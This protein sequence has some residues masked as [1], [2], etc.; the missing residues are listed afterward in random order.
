MSTCPHDEGRGDVFFLDSEGL[1][2]PADGD[3]AELLDQ[4]EI[5]N[6]G[7]LMDDFTNAAIVTGVESTLAIGIV[8]EEEN[9]VRTNDGGNGGSGRKRVLEVAEIANK[10]AIGQAGG[11]IDD[12]D[13]SRASD[14]E[15]DTSSGGSNP[16][17]GCTN[18]F[19]TARDH[20]DNSIDT[21]AGRFAGVGEWK[22]LSLKPSIATFKDNAGAVH[23][24]GRGRAPS[25]GRSA[26]FPKIR[27]II[28][29]FGVGI[30]HGGEGL[31]IEFG[32]EG[33]G[34]IGT[35]SK[36]SDVIPTE[37]GGGKLTEGEVRVRTGG[38]EI[39]N[40]GKITI[41]QKID[42]FT[43]GGISG[44]SD[45]A[46][47]DDRSAADTGAIEGGEGTTIVRHDGV[48]VG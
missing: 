15:L 2:D 11:V 35:E 27:V 19:Y 36:E 25:P 5:R 41:A 20:G 39:D 24:N 10:G 31:I 3:R 14:G 26:E 38:R 42:A 40:F 43:V 48:G 7:T 16:V 6:R 17:R 34:A 46:S 37:N 1:V 28:G 45:G 22:K 47:E 33:E 30:D 44:L 4:T 23:V 18:G 21:N 9:G 32:I 12:R 13:G 29:R 8:G